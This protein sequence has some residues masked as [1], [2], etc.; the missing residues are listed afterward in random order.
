MVFGAVWR[1]LKKW[2]SSHKE[3]HLFLARNPDSKIKWWLPKR[4]LFFEQLPIIWNKIWQPWLFWFVFVSRQKWTG[5]EKG[6]HRKKSINHMKRLNFATIK[7]YWLHF[8]IL[9]KVILSALLRKKE[10]QFRQNRVVPI[11]LTKASQPC[12]QKCHPCGVFGFI[13]IYHQYWH[14]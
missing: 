1:A 4:N 3:I 12:L 8:M 5:K 2:V 9:K 7:W 6:N 14:R 11:V 13:I 10:Q